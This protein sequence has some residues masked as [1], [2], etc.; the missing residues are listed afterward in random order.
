MANPNIVKI[1]EKTQFGKPSRPNNPRPPNPRRG[2][3]KKHIKSV[4][5]E[6]SKLSVKDFYEAKGKKIPKGLDGNKNLREAY[7]AV[8]LEKAMGGSIGHLQILNSL[9]DHTRLSDEAVE[10]LKAIKQKDPSEHWKEVLSGYL[11]GEVSGDEMKSY[12]AAL[13]KAQQNTDF[14]KRINNLTKLLEEVKEGK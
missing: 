13:E 4:L 11:D 1:G 12:V 2:T 3:G 10:R 8:A 14:V 5:R 6:M 7:I 9:Q